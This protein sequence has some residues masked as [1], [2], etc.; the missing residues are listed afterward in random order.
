MTIW[1]ALLIFIS[2]FQDKSI[3]SNFSNVISWFFSMSGGLWI[4]HFISMGLNHCPHRFRL[5]SIMWSW[6]VNVMADLLAKQRVDRECA[7]VASLL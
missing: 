1:E 2:S 5:S 6:L 4:F 3:V 7:L